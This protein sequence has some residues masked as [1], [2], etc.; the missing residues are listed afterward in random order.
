[1]SKRTN[2]TW[3]QSPLVLLRSCLLT[4]LCILIAALA[5]GT[6]QASTVVRIN[7]LG[8]IQPGDTIIVPVTLDSVTVGLDIVGL[9]FLIAWEPTDF[10]LIEA[11][12]GQ[13]LTDCGWEYFN[14]LDDIMTNWNGLPVNIPTVRVVSLAD[15]NNGDIHPTCNATA[16]GELVRLV[17]EVSS[18]PGNYGTVAPIRFLWTDCG[19]NG[20]ALIDGSLIVS[21]QVFDE[22]WDWSLSGPFPTWFGA[23]SECTEGGAV[24]EVDYYNGRVSFAESDTSSEADAAVY[25]TGEREA[26]LGS[27]AY[28]TIGVENLRS[29]WEAAGFEMLI[30]YDHTGISCV[31]VVPSDDLGAWGWE[32]FEYRFDSVGQVRLVV[33]ADM[34]NGN[35]HPSNLLN[36]DCALATLD[37]LVVNNASN[38]GR[39]L[40]LKFLWAD[41]GDNSFAS[42]PDGDSLYIS[43]DVFD[44]YGFLI[45][46]DAPFPTTQGAPEECLT[47]PTVR[48]SVDFFH[49]LIKV[50][51]SNPGSATNRGDIDLNELAYEIADWM[52]FSNYFF[53]G[54]GVFTINIEEQIANTDVNGDGAALGFHDLAYL[55][56]VIVGDVGVVSNKAGAA[57]DTAFII[58]DTLAGSLSVSY[59]T[60]LTLLLLSFSGTVEVV[61]SDGI[62]VE[63]ASDGGNTRMIIYPGF[64]TSEGEQLLPAGFLFN[65]I[66]DGLLADGIA[67]YDGI[68]PIPTR[69]QI[70]DGAP[71]CVDRGNIDHD[72]TGGIDISDLVYLVS[73]MFDLGP[74]PPCSGEADVNGDGSPVADISDLV[75]L[76]DYMFSGGPAPVPCQ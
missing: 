2:L 62:A 60:D 33:V 36:Q 46:T 9:D 14:A 57:V 44:E 45:T 41:C 35:V 21:D 69:V 29:P 20:M 38:I 42:S 31:G 15:I 76:V 53:Y 22:G 56:R 55:Y 39:E 34:N 4:V 65:Y 13:L 72:P 3:N 59:G 25:I 70:G 30:Q 68:N 5:I 1:M 67:A 17:F 8:P 58:Q 49:G 48:R 50:A 12:P 40:P 26:W 66:G 63:A 37:F 27:H 51:T 75:F 11:Q 74:T 18:H 28:A 61:N 32:Y 23:P 6:A 16:P 47:A 73:Y 64:E 24:R 43:N 71:C 54:L 10:R 19:D 7:D 52:L